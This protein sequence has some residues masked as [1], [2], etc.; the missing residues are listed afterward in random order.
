MMHVCSMV[1]DGDGDEQQESAERTHKHLACTLISVQVASTAGQV[2][3]QWRAVVAAQEA[4]ETEQKRKQQE[5]AKAALAKRAGPA[6]AAAAGKGGAAK[7]P[8]S[9]AAAARE[10][11]PVRAK[12]RAMLAES[13]LDFAKAAKEQLEKQKQETAKA[14]AAG[15][16]PPPEQLTQAPELSSSDAA[17]LAS[18]IESEVFARFWIGSSSGTSGSTPQAGGTGRQQYAA[19]L[20]TLRSALRLVDGVSARLL[21]CDGSTGST[22][23]G[24]P[25]QPE[26]IAT[27]DAQ[28]LA[29]AELRAQVGAFASGPLLLAPC[30]PKCILARRP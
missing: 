17:E 27:M 22:G 13:L 29:G 25:L 30:L 24:T 11:E 20:R 21:G 7:E 16:E 5:A 26:D 12:G 10:A 19:R 18:R 28:G 6:A 23:S 2:V 3:A 4:Q 9:A 14:R 8:T 1:T 15:R